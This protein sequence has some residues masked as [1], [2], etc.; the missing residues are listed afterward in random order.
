[1]SVCRAICATIVVFTTVLAVLPVNE[2]TI[3][4][5]QNI[6]YSFEDVLYESMS[7]LN[8]FEWNKK[9]DGVTNLTERQ[10]IV[11]ETFG[12]ELMKTLS[13]VQT[14]LEAYKDGEHL[15][16]TLANIIT[17]AN[18][19]KMVNH[20]I[21]MM[22]T[23]IDLTKNNFTSI[24][25]G[26]TKPVYIVLDMHMN[27]YKSINLFI[28]ETPMIRKYPQ[29]VA[30]I[31][32]SMVPIFINFFVILKEFYAPFAKDTDLACKISLGLL[33]F[34]SLY[35]NYRLTKINTLYNYIE[36]TTGNM[37]QRRASSECKFG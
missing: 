8:E 29:T 17:D 35:I 28:L 4:V 6:H 33:D 5:F 3:E 37:L 27:F 21:Q 13:T 15:N 10:H 26:T 32:I 31:L 12:P 14:M 34:R 23:K 18:D 25:N 2:I 7:I 16:G 36:E 24:T 1:M 30:P 20:E 11:L 9:L 22:K 19:R